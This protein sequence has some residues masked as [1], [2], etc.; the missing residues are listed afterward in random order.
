[1]KE[2]YS[3]YKIPLFFSIAII[4]MYAAFA[5]DLERYDFIRLFSLYAALFFLSYKLIQFNHGNFKFLLFAG[6]L[7]RLIF[8]FALPN[9][10]QDFYRFIWDGRLIANFVNPYLFTPNEYLLNG[11]TYLSQAE[12]LVE[13]MGTLSAGNFSNYPPINQLFFAAAGLFSGIS[14]LGSVIVFRIIILAADVGIFFIG[15]KLLIGIGKDPKHIF[16]YFLNPFIL[17]ELTGNLHFEGAMLFFLLASIYALMKNK[18][19]ISAILMG[20][21]V[22]IKLLPLLFLPILF[23]FFVNTKNNRNLLKQGMRLI[24]YY[25][26]V[27]LCIAVTFLPFLSGEFLQNYSATVAL[28]FQKFEFNASIYYLLRWLGFQLVGWNT[29]AVLG[30]I[31]PIL[32]FIS[33]LLLS[34]LRKN[35]SVKTLF[36]AMLLSIFCYFSLATTVH[37]WYVA[38]PLLLSIFTEY[39]F[40][41]IWSFVV[42]FSYSAYA[43]DGFQENYWL[44]TLEYLIV[45]LFAFA[46]F[47][48]RTKQ[49]IVTQYKHYVYK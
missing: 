15:R 28:W 29:I 37:P 43:K 26:V 49:K 6:I 40:A 46:E 42:F 38:T 1:M 36:T 33:I 17:I 8:L 10:S 35:N 45:F 9:L 25:I 21:S 31:L 14:I 41:Y 13:G 19:W 20:I 23:N 39:R 18:W 44:I 11:S 48:P 3:Q 7:F 24:S 4:A 5:Y 12:D 2:L 34:I 30:K 32:V 27:F 47:F 16:W 22:S